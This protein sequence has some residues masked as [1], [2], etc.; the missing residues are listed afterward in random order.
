MEA[1]MVARNGVD[2]V[3]QESWEVREIIGHSHVIWWLICEVRLHGDMKCG[4]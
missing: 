4:R 2:V 1:R 3:P